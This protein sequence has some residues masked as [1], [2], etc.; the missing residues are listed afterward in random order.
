M[1]CEI[2]SALIVQAKWVIV[3]CIPP[4]FSFLAKPH[5]WL[6]HF[7]EIPTHS[8]LTVIKLNKHAHYIMHTVIRIA[9]TG[10]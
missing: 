5:V 7:K 1:A 4:F 2:A 6:C 3:L 9:L 8:P 10:L